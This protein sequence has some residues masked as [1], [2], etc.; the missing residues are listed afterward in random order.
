MGMI[1]PETLLNPIFT[2]FETITKRSVHAKVVRE[3]EP[4]VG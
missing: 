4:E 2:S 3:K 1:V